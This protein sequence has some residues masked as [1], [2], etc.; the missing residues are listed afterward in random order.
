MEMVDLEEFVWGVLGVCGGFWSS[1][2]GAGNLRVEDGSRIASDVAWQT[3]A[4]RD[5]PRAFWM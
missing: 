3:E 1:E 5:M 2:G 4:E